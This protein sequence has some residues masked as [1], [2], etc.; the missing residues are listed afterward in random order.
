MSILTKYTH[1][2]NRSRGMSKFDVVVLGAG[3]ES[4]CP[5]VLSDGIFEAKS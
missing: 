2:I 5:V 1:Q 4:P 3:S